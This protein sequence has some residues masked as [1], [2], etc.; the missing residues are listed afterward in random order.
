MP[1]LDTVKSILQLEP[2]KPTMKLITMTGGADYAEL[3]QGF[4]NVE[5]ASGRKTLGFNC[6]SFLCWEVGETVV[7]GRDR[8]TLDKPRSEL[9]TVRLNFRNQTDEIGGHGI[10]D[11]DTLDASDGTVGYS[12]TNA[13]RDGATWI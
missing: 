11:T 8:V 13:P 1:F 2:P 4:F 6:P 7:V 3:P 5:G 10:I 12:G 9:P